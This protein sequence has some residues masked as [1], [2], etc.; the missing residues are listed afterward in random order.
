MGDVA[1]GVAAGASIDAATS[2]GAVSLT[3][4][5][6][7]RA[8]AFYEQVLGLVPSPAVPDGGPLALTD[9]GGGPA[10]VVLHEDREAAPFNPRQSGLF[11]LALLVPSR[12]ELARSLRRIAD[13]RWPLTGASDHLVSEALYLRDP[14]GNGIEIYRDRP[15]AQWPSDDHGATR[16]DTLRLDLSELLRE[17]DDDAEP[18]PV[19]AVAA[20]TRIGHVHLQI[21]EL[22]AAERFYCGVLG[23]D[24]TV[25]TYSGALFVSAG[26]YHHHLGLNTW[27]TLGAPSLSAGGVGLRSFE[28]LL[29]DGAAL[30]RALDRLEAGGIDVSHVTGDLASPGSPAPALVRDPFGIAVVLRSA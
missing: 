18:D 27:Q 21:S 10:L 16:M 5:D 8:R 20:G 14:D 30:T 4:S 11:H 2:L 24:V 9:A 13:A 26:G 22:D 1:T 19:P 25:R 15:R 7:G 29:P 17:L 6:L 12:I 3:V 28:V 23:F